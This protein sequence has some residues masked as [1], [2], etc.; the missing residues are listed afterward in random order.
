MEEILTRGSFQAKS[1]KRQYLRYESRGRRSWTPDKPLDLGSKQ[2]RRYNLSLYLSAGLLL[3]PSISSFR[4]LS[5][6]VSICLITYH[7]SLLFFLLSLLFISSVLLLSPIPPS[8]YLSCSSFVL[9]PIP[10]LY[11]LFLLPFL[12]SFSTIPLLFYRFLFYSHSSFLLFI[13]PPHS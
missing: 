10:H 6:S 5:A 3:C 12:V 1:F 2:S 4:F 13:L 9:S 11:L 8:S 7:A